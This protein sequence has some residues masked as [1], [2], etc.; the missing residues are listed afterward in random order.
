L[1]QHLI[2]EGGFAMIDVSDN[3]DIAEVR[4]FHWG[5]DSENSALRPIFTL[6]PIRERF[7]II[8]DADLTG[9]GQSDAR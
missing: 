8:G 4:T 6:G 3:G 2:D 9:I 5:V 7:L 1:T